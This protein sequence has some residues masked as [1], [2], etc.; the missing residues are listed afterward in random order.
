[1]KKGFVV[2]CGQ[3]R[4]FWPKPKALYV[5]QTLHFP[6]LKPQHHGGAASWS[7]FSSAGIRLLVRIKG[8]MDGEKINTVREPASV[9]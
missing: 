9:C 6:C 7:S 3:D 4:A 2:R 1:M 5:V 8:G